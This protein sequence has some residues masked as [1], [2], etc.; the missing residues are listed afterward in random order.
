MR[1]PVFAVYL[2]FFGSRHHFY[3][4]QGRWIMSLGFSPLFT[5]SNFASRSEIQPIL[6]EMPKCTTVEEFDMAQ[7]EDQGPSRSCAS[8]LIDKMTRFR[9]ESRAVYLQNMDKL[10][11]AR[12]LLS[13]RDS[14]RYLSLF[15]I[16][17]ILLPP[18]V[19]R[20]GKFPASALYA[21]H[22]AL[23]RDEIAFRPLSPTSDC[24]RRDHLFE[25]YPLAFV[26]TINKI[27]TVVR[28]YWVHV[29]E[30]PDS[31]R[32]QHLQ[33][34]PLGSFVEQAR[35]IVL[36]NRQRR[37][38][39]N[40]SLAPS[41]ESTI[42]PQVEWSQP[43]AEIISFLEWWASYDM[44]EPSSRFCAYGSAILRALD[45]YQGARLDQSTAWTFLQEIGV[46]PL[47]E[48]PSRYRVRFPETTI[49]RGGGL[50]RSPSPNVQQSVRADIA[51]EYRVPRSEQVFC[52]DGPGAVLIDDG[53]SLEH[54]HEEDEFWIH[55]HAAD[56]ASGIR[57]NS[58]LSR[59]M[60]LIPENIYLQ[61]HFQAMLSDRGGG[62]ALGEVAD[63][64][65]EYSLAPGT[66]ALT[67]SAK[68]NNSGDILDYK[69][70]PTS[71]QNVL[72]MDPRDVSDFCNEPPPPPTTLYELSA[73]TRP[74]NKPAAAFNGRKMTR[75][76]DLD[77]SGRNSLLVL[78][79]LAQALRDKRLDRGA[80]PYYFP[81]S[82][83]EVRYHDI[84]G[85][86]G[87]LPNAISSGRVP[88]DPYIK[89]ATERGTSCSV[90]GD[91]MVLAGQVAARWCAD[92]KIPVPYRKDTKSAKNF[93]EAL[94]Y[95]RTT[96][97][98]QI[99]KGIA[100]SLDQ[101][102]QLSALTGGVEVST[103]PGPYFLMGLDMYAKATSPLRRFSDLL[104][105]WQIHAALDHEHEM[106]R[107]LD[108][109]RDNL[110][111]ILPFPE[112]RMASMLP[113]LHIREKM[114]RAVS[115]G[116]KDWIL[117]ALS[118][119]WRFDGSAPET[120]L[121]T[122]T[123]RWMA[124]LLGRLDMFDLNAMLDKD[125]MGGLVLLKD[126]KVGDQFR[127]KLEDVDVHAGE[128]RVRAIQYYPAPTSAEPAR[129]QLAAEGGQHH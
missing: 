10:D 58:D 5:V 74:P 14:V 76:E 94:N 52:I 39:V 26:Q 12:V 15:E 62:A 90:V 81:G 91:L 48:V 122:V 124:G 56:P 43:S 106:N 96:V 3:G 19:M 1:S 127:V 104:V 123:S 71:L 98:P 119:S 77:W 92:R 68:V 73:G 13:D 18:A 34:T 125:G 9:D 107:A 45:L 75:A 118:R 88:A 21:V 2:G 82:S 36:S 115:R 80:W 37:E 113:L 129:P 89:I 47:W 50:A 111:R 120:F 59:Y 79:R 65:K 23:Y 112:E 126:T 66:P 44:F 27:S 25:V 116:D 57:P 85:E 117:M 69:V 7:K 67:F 108:P 78:Y 63:L 60:E 99:Q 109:N 121:F 31:S 28:D 101:N 103:T 51:A 86:D 114:A 11:R 17:D 29:S 61:G 70:Q 72:Y 8:S 33:Q 22:T 35:Q 95:A 54:T 55:I 16:A 24:H 32:G 83:V 64:V 53:I 105:H 97:Y 6:D 87:A 41:D 42:I 49:V 4:I 110:R 100:P 93:D 40:G 20:D 128:V 46:I 38:W 30:M 102:M 84:I